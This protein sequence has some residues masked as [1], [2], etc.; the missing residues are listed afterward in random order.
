MADFTYQTRQ[1]LRQGW[2]QWLKD[3][4]NRLH[5]SLSS[6]VQPLHFYYEAPKELKS[7]LESRVKQ[8]PEVPLGEIYRKYLGKLV[9]VCVPEGREEE[10]YYAINQLNQYQMTTGPNRRSMRGKSYLP[11]IEHSI[12]ILWSYSWL[13]YV[14][15]DLIDLFTGQADE[16]L[17]D[18]ARNEHWRYADILSAEIDLEKEKTIS[19]I[20]TI[21]FGEN[22]TSMVTTQLIC[23]IT[24]SKN[25]ELY[26]LLGNFLLAARLQEGVRQAVCESMDAGRPEAFL[27]LFQL[28]EDNNLIRYSSVKRA[29]S[30]WIGIFDENNVDRISGKLVQ[31]MGLCLRDPAIREEFLHSEDSV[32]ISVA[33]WAKGFYDSEDAIKAVFDLIHHGT[34]HQKMTASYFNQSLQLDELTF[35]AAKGILFS[36]PEDLELAAC[37]LPSLFRPYFLLNA[38]FPSAQQYNYLKQPAAEPKKIPITG[39]FETTEEAERMYQ[40]L[41]RLLL[42]LPKKG[43]EIKPCIFPWYQV[44]LT[45]SDLAVRLCLLAWMLQKEEYLDEAA[46]LLPAITQHFA[47]R[48]L[49][50]RVLLYQPASRVRKEILLDLLHNPESYTRSAAESLAE[51]M[52]WE[53]EDYQYLEKNLK[54]KNGRAEMLAFLKQQTPHALSRSIQR[55]LTEKS[56]ECHMGALDLALEIKNKNPEEFQ[57][58]RPHLALLSH[59]TG[60]EEILLRELDEGISEAQDILSQP[61]YGFYD[62]S[63]Q[64]VLPPITVDPSRASS[65][66]QYKDPDYMRILN[67]L[68]ALIEKHKNREYPLAFGGQ[69]LLGTHFWHSG[70]QTENTT[71]LY[72]YPFPEL[73]LEFYEQEIQDPQLLLETYLYNLCRGTLYEKKIDLYKKVFG[74]GLF[75]HAPFQNFVLHLQF[76]EHIG[77]I[78]SNLFTEKVPREQLGTWGQIITAKLLSLLTDSNHTYSWEYTLS[79][80][81]KRTGYQK[82][83]QFPVFREAVNWL[84]YAKEEDW[85]NAFTLKFK[86]SQ[87][88]QNKSNKEKANQPQYLYQSSDPRTLQISDL[89]QAYVR[90]IWT[91]DLFYKGI[92]TFFSLTDLFVPISTVEQKGLLS[93]RKVNRGL[94]SF[95]GSDRFQPVDGKYQFDNIGEEMP[96]MTFAHTLYQEIIPQVLK[97]ELRRGEQATPFSKQIGKI[98]VIYGIDTLIQILTALGTDTLDRNSYSYGDRRSSLSHLLSVCFP[99][100]EET[101][102]DLKR[103]LKGSN[104][105]QKRLIEVAMYAKQWIPLLEE[106]LKISGFQSG[107]YYFMA[108]TCEALDE[109]TNA[110]IAR[111]TPLS[112]EE[113]RDGA[114]DLNWFWEAYEKLGEKQF[115]L[116]YDAAKYSSSGSAHSRARKYANAALGTVSME[117]LTTEIEAKRNKDLLMSLGLL[118]FS[119][120]E[121]EKETDL[122]ARYQFI[123]NFKKESR[124][125]GAQRRASEGRA[126]EIALRNLSTA[127]G[128]TDV[129]R[130]TL[131]MESALSESL[132]PYFEWTRLEDET[133]IRIQVDETGKSHLECQKKDKLLKSIPAKLKK[134]PIV[135][136]YQEVNKKLKDQHSRT[137][138]MLEQAMEDRTPFEAWELLHLQRNPVLQPIAAPLV[139]RTDSA[140]GFLTEEGL[141][142]HSG[143]VIPISPKETVRIAHPFDLYQSGHWQDYQTYL[144]EHQIRQ[145]F[146]QVFRELY[147]KLPE[148][149]EQNYSLLFAGNQI[150]PAKTVGALKSRRWIADYDDGLQKIYYKENIVARIYAMADWFSPSDIEAPTLEYVEFFDRKTFEQIPI[151]Q[152][153]DILYSEVMR[154]VDLAVSV[155]HAGGVDPETSHSTVEMRRAI[156]SCNLE[157]FRIQNVTLQ[158]NHAIIE[159][160]RA[161]YSVHLGSGIVHQIGGSMLYLVPVH[162]QHRGRLFLPFIDEDPK[163]AEILSKVLLFAEDEKIKDP[164]LLEQIK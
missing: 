85:G 138:Q 64:W 83:I 52:E 151:Q 93:S 1:R 78:L 45:K 28:I 66:F 7:W 123:Q 107:C 74:S 88:Y 76:S 110:R 37:F 24:K 156:L 23:G 60:K 100:P 2:I 131:R 118:P 69:S 17:I 114:F 147:V 79:N 127:A 160:K 155:A 158:D 70:S 163:T 106:Y 50:A 75:K 56:E 30:T 43:L 143:T 96:E 33:L 81:I 16:E 102:E 161:C 35:Q 157:L 22:N 58:I 141:T 99:Y 59:P 21:F 120:Q 134:S 77:I 101:A 89:V 144:F 51:C 109:E 159:G 86:L 136:D 104:I 162:S 149:L 153:P 137:R 84:A 61:G 115:K 15:V 71:P 72:R 139:V 29:V 94:S 18:F 98:Q 32:A 36:Y 148:E 65:F 38:C 34:R 105:T 57:S 80:G 73:W 90:G 164:K 44:N 25:Q 20:R 142:D 92:F 133:S 31:Q 6:F 111:Y 19:G 152:I 27:Y 62:T 55:L 48:P 126:V 112:P 10:F 82:I 108:H 49:A 26:Q 145:S 41:T 42:Q 8:L 12:L 5:P 117:S 146:K 87:C 4:T 95:F 13:N 53:P 121:K 68:D 132:Q 91:K 3:K 47:L 40:I 130:L 122:L 54:Y 67:K 9:S 113:L 103:A 154:D 119:K 39:F 135:L 116:L 128:F 14:Q 63:V 140:F 46:K 11:F 129:T 124:R 125:F 150:Q 97:V